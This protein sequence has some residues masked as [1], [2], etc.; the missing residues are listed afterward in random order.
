M[1]ISLRL[2]IGVMINS[3]KYLAA[4]TG[5]FRYNN[6]FNPEVSTIHLKLYT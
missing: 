3:K 1:R 4:N 2:L 5:N 6:S